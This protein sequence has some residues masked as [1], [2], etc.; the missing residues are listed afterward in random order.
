M[1]MQQEAPGANLAPVPQR[2]PWPRRLA[3][4]V[5]R[6]TVVLPA[7]NLAV[8]FAVWEW[9]GRQI[10][11]ILFAPP[12]RVVGVFGQLIASGE[13]PAATVETVNTLAVGYALSVAVALPGGILIARRPVLGR[14]LD[15]YLDAIYATPRVVIVPLVILWFGVGYNGRLF[16]IFLG[17]VIPI[18]VS[19]AVGVRDARPDLVEVAHSFGASGPQVVRHVQLPAAVPF[20]ASGL[21]IGAERAVVGVVVGEIFLELTGIGGLIQLNAVRFRT[22][23]VLSGVVVIAFIG[24][25]F[26]GL[27]DL[28][29]R[30]VSPWRATG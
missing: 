9:V 13:L 27:L 28:L 8:F 15:P 7:L 2:V 21:R 26:I 1:V 4:I 24:I 3:T 29:E 10:D 18:I 12:S 23:E 19:T 22:A 11:P 25:V 6:P 17:T 20:V 16:L 30:R 14:V 5:R